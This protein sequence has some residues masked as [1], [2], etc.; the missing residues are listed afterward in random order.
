MV[1]LYLIKKRVF[2]IYYPASHEWSEFVLE[3]YSICKI[4][5]LMRAEYP[6]MRT[7]SQTTES[8]RHTNKALQLNSVKVTVVLS[9]YGWQTYS[10]YQYQSMVL[11]FSFSKI[12]YKSLKRCKTNAPTFIPGMLWL[13]YK[14]FIIIMTTVL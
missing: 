6:Y 3:N 5:Y 1:R 8:I 10:L 2:P 13:L 9:P 11:F 14:V 7:S 4:S 12:I